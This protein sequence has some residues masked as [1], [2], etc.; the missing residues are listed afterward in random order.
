MDQIKSFRLQKQQ[1]EELMLQ[2]G[3]LNKLKVNCEIDPSTIEHVAPAPAGRNLTLLDPDI[4]DIPATPAD[5]I[6]CLYSITMRDPIPR[7]AVSTTLYDL[8]C[9]NTYTECRNRKTFEFITTR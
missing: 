4:C 1:E 6:D 8:W 3:E 7:S 9:G 5:D 2:A